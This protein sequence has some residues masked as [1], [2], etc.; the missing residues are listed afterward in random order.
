MCDWIKEKIGH[1]GDWFRFRIGRYLLQ[2][3]LINLVKLCMKMDGALFWCEINFHFPFFS[4]QARKHR[5]KKSFFVEYLPGGSH[6]FSFSKSHPCSSSS[7]HTFKSLMMIFSKTRATAAASSSKI[8]I[9][10]PNQNELAI[11]TQSLLLVKKT[12]LLQFTNS[13]KNIP[14]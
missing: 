5:S 6:S 2:K 12:F 10:N 3:L 8:K 14:A 13:R 9:Q 4:P 7:L 11:L 1:L